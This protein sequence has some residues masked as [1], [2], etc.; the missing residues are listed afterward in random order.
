MFK[1]TAAF[2]PILAFCLGIMS[3]VQAAPEAAPKAAPKV[4]ASILPVHSLVAGVMKS[5]AAPRL[6]LRGAASPHA[7]ALRPSD[8][9]AI[10]NADL[11]FW[12]GSRL[13]SFLA[14]P[15]SALSQKARVIELAEL[16]GISHLELGGQAGGHIGGRDMHIWL[17]PNNASVMVRHMVTN[18]SAKDPTNA[19]L[20]ETNGSVLL[21]RLE[22]AA[23][24]IQKAVNRVKDRPFVVYHHAYGHFITRFGL[25]QTGFLTLGAER[26]P[27]AKRLRQIKQQILKKNVVCVFGERQQNRSLLNTIAE[28]TGAR[29]GMLDALGVGVAPGADAYFKLMDKLTRDFVNCLSRK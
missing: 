9:R 21:R 26:S 1:F 5:V 23:G 15:L 17:D 20:Y 19:K 16:P 12:I 4:V 25:T 18:L 11:V 22:T 27:G 2:L 10:H 7:Q 3:P 29:I 14:K 28:G 13:E 8:A 24:E 6:L